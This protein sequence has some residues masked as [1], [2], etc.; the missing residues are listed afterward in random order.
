MREIPVPADQQ[1]HFAEHCHKD[2]LHPDGFDVRAYSEDER[3]ESLEMAVRINS[4]E[5]RYV[6]PLR[7]Y[8]WIPRFFADLNRDTRKWDG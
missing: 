8:E 7:Q 4:R 6:T 5:Y 2:G 1:Q 3:A